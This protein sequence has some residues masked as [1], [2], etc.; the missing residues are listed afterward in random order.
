MKI[1]NP[2]TNL[3]RSIYLLMAV[4]AIG[5]SGCSNSSSSSSDN[6]DE[7]N[8]QDPVVTEQSVNIS[9]TLSTEQEVPAVDGAGTGTATIKVGRTSG[10][11]SG[12]L[13]VTGLTGDVNAAHIHT[14][15]AGN[16]GGV[17]IQLEMGANNTLSIPD[18]TVLDANQL[19]DLL[20]GKTYFN[21]HTTA[22]PAGEVRGQIIPDTH[23]LIRVTLNGDNTVPQI[24]AT[25]TASGIGYIT[26]NMTGNREIIANF[27]ATNLDDATAAHI[28]SGFA[29]IAGGVVTS[30]VQD[31]TNPAFWV[32][33]DDAMLTQ[34]EL[35]TLDEAGLYI[36]VHS[37]ANAS[38]EI[39]GQISPEGISVVRSVLSGDQE[40]PAVMTAGSGVGYAT[41]NTNN[42]ELNANITTSDLSSGATAAHIH[43]GSAGANGGVI[44]GLVQ[45]AANE[46]VWATEVGAVLTAEQIIIFSSG[47]TYFNVHTPTNAAG[48]VRGQITP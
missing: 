36:N 6:D 33:A 9:T 24:P 41:V 44:V 8:I 48:E 20:A 13:T 28:H 31:G 47:E 34:E 10:S 38:G 42:G 22:N 1:P 11:I 39:R 45:D 15:E 26:I 17:I 23:K 40:V 4:T 2:I 37:L 21:V 29:G 14:A 35:D 25:T 32:L 43:Q 19:A 12:T 18:G 16:N 3:R 5:V 30:F 7:D 46:A 27:T